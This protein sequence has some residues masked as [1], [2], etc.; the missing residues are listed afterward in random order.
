M[1]SKT[2]W[3][4]NVKSQFSH[5]EGH[6]GPRLSVYL[7]GTSGQVSYEKV[8]VCVCCVIVSSGV[9]DY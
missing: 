2:E 9:L 4:I 1:A 8:Q 3:D 6:C 7:V 5:E